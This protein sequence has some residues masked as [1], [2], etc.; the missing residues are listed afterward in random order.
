MTTRDGFSWTPKDGPSYGLP[1]ISYIHPPHLNIPDANQTVD[2]IVIGAGYAGLIAARDLTIQGKPLT[3]YKEVVLRELQER[4][5]FWSRQEIEL[6]GEPFTPRLMASIMIWEAHGCIGICL[7][8]IARC[9]S[10]ACK[11]IGLS[12]RL[13]VD[14]TTTLP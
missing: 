10:M 7:I 3:T 2:A 6:A 12:H 14:Q 8:S 11:R 9:R 4:G 1:S 13:M 5:R